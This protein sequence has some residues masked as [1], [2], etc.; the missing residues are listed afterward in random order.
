[1]KELKDTVE[2]MLS[3]NWQDRLKAEIYQC[4]IRREKLSAAV[5]HIPTDDPQYEMLHSQLVHMIDYECDLTNRAAAFGIEL[6]SIT[7]KSED[8]ALKSWFENIRNVTLDEM[9]NN[10]CCCPN[11]SPSPML[12]PNIAFIIGSMFGMELGK[13]GDK[14]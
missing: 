6:E 12:D 1:M 13:D 14:K 7:D 5:A 3:D 2:L 8:E 11:P 10:C 4:Q 9:M